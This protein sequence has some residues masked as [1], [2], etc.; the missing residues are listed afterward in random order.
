MVQIPDCHCFHCLKNA[1][2]GDTEIEEPVMELNCIRFRLNDLWM[3]ALL[4]L[5]LWMMHLT[6]IVNS[7][8]PQMIDERCVAV[9]FVPACVAEYNLVDE[10]CLL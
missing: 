3:L 6:V 5:D 4:H 1:T 10:G 9:V 2:D 7:H 8:C